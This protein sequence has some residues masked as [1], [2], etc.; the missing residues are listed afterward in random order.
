MNESS[1]KKQNLE[2]E[3]ELNDKN[4]K[5]AKLKLEEE[6]LKAILKKASEK[7][8]A[9]K[10]EWKNV[11]LQVKKKQ[12]LKQ[13][14]DAKLQIVQKEEGL[15]QVVEEENSL[16]I[17]IQK[18]TNEINKLEN[19]QSKMKAKLMSVWERTESYFQS[20]AN[21]TA[22]LDWLLAKID[23]EEANLK[24]QLEQERVRQLAMELSKK[25]IQGKACP[26]C[27][28]T[29]H[30][31]V[32]M[33]N[34]KK[35][36]Q[37]ELEEMEQLRKLIQKEYQ[38]NITIKVK[39]E[40]LASELFEMLQDTNFPTV[41][42]ED[43]SLY[44]WERS[45]PKEKN[46]T[47]FLK[48]L[49][50]EVSSE[51]KALRQDVLQIT[52]EKEALV[53]NYNLRAVNKDHLVILLDTYNVDWQKWSDRLIQGE[54]EIDLLKDQWMDTF[55]DVAYQSLENEIVTINKL[56]EEMNALQH[57]LLKSVEFIDKKREE[58]LEITQ[59]INKS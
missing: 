27:G 10:E 46:S 53:A 9:L 55:I 31:P 4:D 52:K 20:T 14:Y 15:K 6:K 2:S 23:R 45:Y 56:Q 47:A 25:L 43:E 51:Q 12:L 33:E 5:V 29:Q 39:F 54:K 30:K 16:Y 58:L 22:K 26:V 21:L 49:F 57:R 3:I 44:Q 24:E 41:L 17:K 38:Q 8:K 34:E 19:N 7:Q 35:V 48:A 36:S 18:T 42:H 28:S 11:S 13:A 32:I 1:D 40:R 50:K 59:K 37:E